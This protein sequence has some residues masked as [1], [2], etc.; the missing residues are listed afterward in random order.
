MFAQS[1]NDVLTRPDDVLSPEPPHFLS[2]GGRREGCCAGVLSRLVKAPR[3]APVLWP[4][5]RRLRWEFRVV[6]S[7]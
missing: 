4:A 1:R 5:F 6:K 2:E 3:R 7:S